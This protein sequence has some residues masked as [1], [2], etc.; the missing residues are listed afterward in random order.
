[1]NLYESIKTNLKE[2]VPPDWSSD[3]GSYDGSERYSPDEP[4]AAKQRWIDDIDDKIDK[5]ESFS[6]LDANVKTAKELIDII[7]KELD[8]IDS[9]CDWIDYKELDDI[10]DIAYD[11]DKNGYWEDTYGDRFDTID[12]IKDI[13]NDSVKEALAS[14]IY[15]KDNE[16]YEDWYDRYK[17]GW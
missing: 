7:Y 1:M 9:Q 12:D 2:S 8:N 10:E 5:A 15:D 14:Y 13:L 11:F 4:S 16:S 3:C 17:P 6:I